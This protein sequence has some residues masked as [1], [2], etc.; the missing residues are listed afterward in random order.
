M[1]TPPRFCQPD[2]TPF[3]N[4][5]KYSASS[6]PRTNTA[7]CPGPHETAPGSERDTPPRF[8]ALITP[9]VRGSTPPGTAW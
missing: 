7:E 4:C 8:S 5:M 6:A 2:D 1:I 9:F 3:S